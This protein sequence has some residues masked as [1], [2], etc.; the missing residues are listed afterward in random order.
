MKRTVIIPE[1][2]DTVILNQVDIKKYFGVEVNSSS[3]G[4]IRSKEYVSGCNPE[5]VWIIGSSVLFTSGNDFPTLVSGAGHH[6]AD[7]DKCFLSEFIGK[8]I[9][10]GYNV[11][12]FDSVSE[13]FSWMEEVNS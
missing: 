6:L 2:S 7:G 10:A 4:F 8:I 1:K 11:Y 13:L 5:A 12:Q 9:S 3:A